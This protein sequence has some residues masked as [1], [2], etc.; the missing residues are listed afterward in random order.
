MHPNRQRCTKKLDAS[1]AYSKFKI[2]NEQMEIRACSC[3]SY[4]V[5]APF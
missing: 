3:P 4:N 1:T 5:R 2:E